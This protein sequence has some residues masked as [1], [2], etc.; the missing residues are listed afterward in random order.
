MIW[1]LGLLAFGED[2]LPELWAQRHEGEL[3]HLVDGSPQEAIEIFKALLKGLSSSH[4]LYGE[5]LFSLGRAQYDIGDVIGAKKSIFSSIYVLHAPKEAYQYYVD[6]LAEESPLQT[7]PYS[8]NPWVSIVDG[9][10]WSHLYA[11]RIQEKNQQIS[12]VNIDL[13]L[14]KSGLVQLLIYG[15]KGRE[16]KEEYTL[17]PGIHRISLS[18][19]RIPKELLEEGIFL[20][21]LQTV[22]EEVFWPSSL[23]IK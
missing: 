6:L 19:D 12:V 3:V 4:P 20:L 22:D 18:H 8:G 23:E 11:V 15:T 1:L 13:E 7:I 16:Y 21:E 17:S 10:K 5:L 9:D 2:N 14:K